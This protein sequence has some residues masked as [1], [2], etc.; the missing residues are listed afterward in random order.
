MVGN[1]VLSY[2]V[3]R[4][5]LT[6]KETAEPKLKETRESAMQIFERKK[7]HFSPVQRLSDRHLPIKSEIW[8]EANMAKGVKEKANTRWRAEAKKVSHGN[9]SSR[10]LEDIVRTCFTFKWTGKSMQVLRR[11]VITQAA[12]LRIGWGEGTDLETN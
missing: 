3:V 4:L 6:E 1:S 2:K 10:T 7:K 8:I 9:R 11:R 5:G 12:E